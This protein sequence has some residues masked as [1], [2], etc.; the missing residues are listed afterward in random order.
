MTVH[1]IGDD[2]ELHTICL[3][4]KHV[5]E[6]H[7]AA[8]TVAAVL[9][10]LGRFNL[11]D[12][13]IAITHDN[14]SPMV[15]AARALPGASIRCADHSL[16]LVVLDA[17][18]ALPRKLNTP[19]PFL[20]AP[21]TTPADKKHCASHSENKVVAQTLAK[22]KS[23]VT[24]VRAS[25]VSKAKLAEDRKTHGSSELVCSRLCGESCFWLDR[26]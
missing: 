8:N 2:W 21:A 20:G 9:D 26:H 25:P 10:V 23:V 3:D 5:P 19:H 13:L 15:A 4:V 24:Y 17:L 18:S 12:K 22:V 11:T 14:A 7:D 16:N 1:W 6:K